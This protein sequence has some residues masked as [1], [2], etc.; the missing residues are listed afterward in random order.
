[1]SKFERGNFMEQK[2]K[3]STLGILAL[4]FSVLGC[5]FL[6][7]IILAIIDLCK[8]DG[9]KKTLSIIALVI[10][11][12]WI[13]SALALGGSD[14]QPTAT[15]ELAT[16]EE[17]KTEAA[18]ESTTEAQTEEATTEEATEDMTLGQKNALASAKDYLIYSAFSHK[19]LIQQLEFEG[20]S[21]EDATFAADNCGADWNEQAAR[22]AQSYLDYD[23]YSRQGLIEQL[24]YEGFTNE[25]A[26]YGVTAVGY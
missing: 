7:G 14:S 8:K 22:S 24:L 13:I 16:T 15:T 18:T 10:C 3:N 1:M 20:Y 6:V 12:F 2:P 4:I 19:G 25:Q 11:G 23:S 9:Q 5:T 26:E 21:T 17:A